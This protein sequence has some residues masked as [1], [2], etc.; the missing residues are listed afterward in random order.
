MA[1]IASAT[2]SARGDDRIR[3]EPGTAYTDGG[4]HQ[5][6][7]EY[8][9]GLGQRPMRDGKQQHR[10]RAHGGNQARAAAQSQV[11][12]ADQHHAQYAGEATGTGNP[13]FQMACAVCADAGEPAQRAR[14]G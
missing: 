4:G 7:A 1:L 2:A 12:L 11:G 3:V 14:A 13:F 10:G 9:P 8:G 5:V 6:S